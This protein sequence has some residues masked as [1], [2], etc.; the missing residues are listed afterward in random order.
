MN[1]LRSLG[2]IVAVGSAAAVLHPSS[3]R[4]ADTVTTPYPG[5]T[6]LHRTVAGSLELHALTVDLCAP[7]IAVRATAPTERQ[8]TVSAFGALIGAEAAV[9]ADFF[10]FA[11]YRTTGLAIGSGVKWSDTK[12]DGLESSI[13]FGL[14]HAAVLGAT[15]AKSPDA[16]V[17]DLVSSR[18]QILAG[19][20]I[21]RG[22]STG[23]C[24]GPITAQGD[25]TK[26]PRTGI[27]LSQ[28][29][30]KLYLVVV[31]GRQAASDGMTTFELATAMKALGAWDAVNMD[32]GGSTQMWIKGNGIVNSPS[33]G[34][35]RVVANHLA[36]MAGGSTPPKN[37]TPVAVDAGSAPDAAAPS[38][39][40]SEGVP[41]AGVPSATSDAGGNA[42]S[43][44]PGDT[45]CGC[46]TAGNARGG[47]TRPAWTVCLAAFGVLVARARRRARRAL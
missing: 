45:G 1:T 26:D 5:M 42:D 24:A 33:D 22:F 14:D 31:D 35:E 3:A 18:P 17:T 25:C 37:C 27:G 20:V 6:W 40:G 11:D 43:S 23:V 30:R 15:A 9:N 2:F 12:N 46:R 28:D 34:S 39:S 7:G 21:K 38:D 29:Q 44:S 47:G 4:A 41:D 32:S 8:K 19:G 10:S 36:V 16:W 13:A